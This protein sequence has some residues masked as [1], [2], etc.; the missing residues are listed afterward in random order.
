MLLFIAEIAGSEP[1]FMFVPPV[2]F[3]LWQVKKKV[4]EDYTIWEQ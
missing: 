1:L 3:L 4:Y 2:H